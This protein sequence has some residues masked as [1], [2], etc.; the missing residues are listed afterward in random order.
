MEYE[1]D[2]MIDFEKLGLYYEAYMVGFD[3]ECIMY[4]VYFDGGITDEK[5]KEMDEAIQSYLKSFDEDVY[6]G[7]IDVRQGE[8]KGSIYLD[9]GNVEPPN[10]DIAVKGILKALNNVSGIK[11]VMLNEEFWL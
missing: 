9:I 11:K 8:G 1:F 5:F 7:Y 10:E 4:S 2:F 3:G 6:L